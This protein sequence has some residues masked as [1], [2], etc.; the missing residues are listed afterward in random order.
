MSGP[1]ND[2]ET[3]IFLAAANPFQLTDVYSLLIRSRLFVM[4]SISPDRKIA[5]KHWKVDEK[6]LI[7]A[8]TSVER[9]REAITHEEHYIEIDTVTFLKSIPGDSDVVLNPNSRFALELKHGEIVKV[10]EETNHQY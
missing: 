5:L 1:A 7:P 8:F 3:A 10:L 9:L 4:G 6:P 2:L